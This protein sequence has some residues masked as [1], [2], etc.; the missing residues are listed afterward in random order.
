VRP[1]GNRAGEAV[2]AVA[3]ED[4]AGRRRGGDGVGGVFEC[5]RAAWEICGTSRCRVRGEGA[6]SIQHR[7]VEGG[8]DWEC[9]RP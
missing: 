2:L 1:A 9:V 3:T 6:R 7:V 5:R 4:L 8:G